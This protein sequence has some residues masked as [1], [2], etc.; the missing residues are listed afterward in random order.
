MSFAPFRRILTSHDVSDVDGTNVVVFDDLVG[1]APIPNGN[2]MS[3]VYASR[4]LPICTKHSTTSEEIADT[5]QDATDIVTPGGTNGRVAVLPPNG[6]FAR[7]RTDSVDYNIIMSGSGFHVTPGPKG[8]VWTPVKAGEVV[9]QRGTLH[10]W[11]AG[12]EGMRWFSV[13]IAADSVQVNGVPLKAI[14]L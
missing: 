2:G 5:L 4:G 3:P 12:T 9:I 8:D 1:I 11:Q 6:S 10:A 14:G 7:H 13:I